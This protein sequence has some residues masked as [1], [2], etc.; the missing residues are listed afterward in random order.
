LTRPP[1][2]DLL[3]MIGPSK[4]RSVLRSGFFALQ[5]RILIKIGAVFFDFRGL[6]P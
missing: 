4:S 1:D 6:S 5:R 3:S 2:G